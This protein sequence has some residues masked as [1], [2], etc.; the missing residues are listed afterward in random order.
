MPPP[1]R[2]THSTVPETGAKTGCPAVSPSTLAQSSEYLYWVNPLRFVWVPVLYPCTTSHSPPAIGQAIPVLS[3]LASFGVGSSDVDGGAAVGTGVGTSPDEAFASGAAGGAATAAP[4][5]SSPSATQPE[6][7]L[8]VTG[9]NPF[10]TGPSIDSGA[11]EASTVRTTV[12]TP[13]PE[14]KFVSVVVAL[15]DPRDGAA[16][17]SVDTGGASVSGTDSVTGPG[18]TEGSTVMELAG[19]YPVGT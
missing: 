11:P 2:S 10:S 12:S 17:E 16:T 3:P 4:A 5:P 8:P 18:A 15:G 9:T 14:C 6:T 1:P 19:T 7:P 13:G